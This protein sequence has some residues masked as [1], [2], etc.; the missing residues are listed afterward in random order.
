MEAETISIVEGIENKMSLMT[1][2][3]SRQIQE[4]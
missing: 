2:N 3:T 4:I 1:Q